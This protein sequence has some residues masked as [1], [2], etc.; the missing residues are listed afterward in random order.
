VHRTNV[1]ANE[2]V[3]N[4]RRIELSLTLFQNDTHHNSQETQQE[5]LLRRQD[6]QTHNF[7]KHAEQDSEVDHNSTHKQLSEDS[8]H[9][10]R[11]A[12]ER[13]QEQKLRNDAEV[14]HRTDSHSLKHEKKNKITTLLSMNVIDAF[15]HVFKE[16]LLHNLRKKNIS[17]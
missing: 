6:I 17:N 15:D 12:D 7:I 13:S 3:S 1:L 8:R 11:V 16:K 2:F 9:A 14:A 5:R 4:L 10:S